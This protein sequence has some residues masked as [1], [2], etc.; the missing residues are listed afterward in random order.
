MVHKLGVA[1]LMTLVR[2][3]SQGWQEGGQREGLWSCRGSAGA[4]SATNPSHEAGFADLSPWTLGLSAVQ[5]T[6]QKHV[7]SL[8]PAHNQEEGSCQEVGLLRGQ[9]GGSLLT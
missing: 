2:S 5:L 3:L 1:Q 4:G 7:L 8:D 9:L 6:T